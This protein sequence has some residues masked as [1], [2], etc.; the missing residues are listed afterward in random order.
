M[1]NQSGCSRRLARCA[2]SPHQGRRGAGWGQDG[3]RW[4]VSGG[5]GCRRRFGVGAT[6]RVGRAAALR[7]G[8]G[9]GGACGGGP[10]PAGRSSP[11]L[12]AFALCVPSALP[13]APT[14]RGC[15]HPAFRRGRAPPFRAALFSPP[16][17]GSRLPL[18]FEVAGP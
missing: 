14:L 6:L 2:R 1:A 3:G 13:A 4:G 15:R 18:R 11:R 8:L 9:S 7:G 17:A 12:G 5:S 10:L 16:P